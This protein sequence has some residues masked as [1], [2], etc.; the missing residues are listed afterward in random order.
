MAGLEDIWEDNTHLCPKPIDWGFYK[1]LTG[2]LN[3]AVPLTTAELSDLS[4]LS[5]DVRAGGLVRLKLLEG[6]QV[7]HLFMFNPQDPDERYWAQHTITTES[8]FMSRYSR[9]WGTMARHRPLMAFLEDTVTPPRRAVSLE[10]RHHPCFTG[11]G[12]PA[13]WR[14]VGGPDGVV[15]PWEQMA[16]LMEERG[17]SSKLIKDDACLFQKVRLDG[18]SQHLVPLPSDA[19]AGDSVT[20]FAEIDLVVL[21]ALSPFVDGSADAKDAVRIGVRP[22]EIAVTE[23]IAEP[24]GW[25]YPD[26]GYPDLSLY[27]D[28]RGVRSEEPVPTAGR[29]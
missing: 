28:E 15:T 9:L 27:L 25:P 22:V 14:Y 16:G 7:V 1:E 17:V 10:G 6:A 29:E 5:L 26:I 21:L 3:E 18:Y 8:L 2:R 24:L 4:G 19:L 11:F 23:P 12:T 20:L 13:Y